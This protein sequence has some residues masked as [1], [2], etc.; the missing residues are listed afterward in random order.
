MHVKMGAV[1]PTFSL[2][3]PLDAARRVVCASATKSSAIAWLGAWALA[4]AA[5]APA[6]QAQTSRAG[7]DTARPPS[8]QAQTVLCHLGFAGA[9]RTFVI[10]PSRFTDDVY[11]LVEGASFA[12][13][14][15]NRLP[16][17]PGAGVQ[18][19]TYAT[20]HTQPFLLH[21]ATFSAQGGEGTHGFTGLQVV[22]EPVRGHEIAYW[23]ERAA[24]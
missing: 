3:S 10:P 13:Q 24:R 11:P 2:W 5:G 9:Q 17:E 19:S 14:V 20:G 15:V 8:A 4:L 6:A 1:M 22:R 23:C 12:F 21:Q 18:V 16:P 7:A